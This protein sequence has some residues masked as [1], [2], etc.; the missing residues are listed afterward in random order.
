[1]STLTITPTAESLAAQFTEN[2]GR[3]ILDSGDAYGRGFERRAGMT[4]ADFLAAPEI[5]IDGDAIWLNT[6]HVLLKH[7]TLTGAA[8]DLTA[9]FRAYV[10]ATPKG[11]AYYNAYRS[12]EDWLE[13]IGADMAHSDNTYNHET[14]LD[15]VLQYVLFT[16]ESVQYVALSTHNGADVRGGYS[17]YVIYAGCDDWLWSST[18]ADLLCRMCNRQITVGVGEIIVDGEPYDGEIGRNGECPACR[19]PE[20]VSAG[21]RECY[22]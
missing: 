1:M 22:E 8:R 10:D 18:E 7:L 13:T 16:Y 9:D 15:N 12:V 5:T 19:W 21:L 11:E 6:F 20:L 17:D 14:F 2:T 3:H 4:A